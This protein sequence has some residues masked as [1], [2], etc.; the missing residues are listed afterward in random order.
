MKYAIAQGTN[1]SYSA[2]DWKD[3]VQDLNEQNKALNV[4]E[5]NTTSYT[6]YWKWDYMRAN[7]DQEDT[8]IGRNGTTTQTIK[9]TVKATQAD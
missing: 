3:S 4:G 7:K 5:S 2:L 1:T 9:A 8:D 6:V